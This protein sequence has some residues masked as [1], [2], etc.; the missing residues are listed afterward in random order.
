MQKKLYLCIKSKKWPVAWLSFELLMAVALF[1]GQDF[2]W[3]S[4]VDFTLICI[5][6]F[7]GIFYICYEPFCLLIRKCIILFSCVLSIE[8]IRNE[9][10]WFL[11]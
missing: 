7:L 1:D 6:S 5:P 9:D 4:S 3:V 11:C 2:C 10:C 8:L